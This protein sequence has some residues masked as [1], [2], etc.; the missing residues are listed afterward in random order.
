MSFEQILMS[1]S[2]FE[3]AVT[4]PGGVSPTASA[5]GSGFNFEVSIVDDSGTN[6]TAEQQELIQDIT[7]A[8]LGRWAN[9]ILGSPRANISV[10][11]TIAPPEDN[12][13]VASAGPANFVSSGMTPDGVTILEANTIAE[14]RS[15]D[16]V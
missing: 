16:D 4:P 14:L 11:V 2:T 3:T 8:A 1:S 12:T 15:G 9:F 13:T 7:E 6:V 10:L 5:L